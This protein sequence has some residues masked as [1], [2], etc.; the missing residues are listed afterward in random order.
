MHIEFFIPWD[1]APK[2]SVR[3]GRA[4]GSGKRNF[5]PTTRVTT[6][7]QVLASFVA[8]HRPARPLQG[9]LRAWYTVSYAYIKRIAKKNRHGPVPKDTSPDTEQ[10]AKQLGDTLESCGFFANDGQ[11]ADLRVVKVWDAKPGVEVMIEEID[12]IRRPF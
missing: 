7:A 10:L 12:G 4:F 2:Q 3:G 1:V 11:I 6:N 9:A 5:F 8:P